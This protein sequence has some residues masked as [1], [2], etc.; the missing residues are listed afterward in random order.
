MHRWI[1][2]MMMALTGALTGQTDTTRR[3]EII[4][5]KPNKIVYEDGESGSAVIRLYN[6]TD[7][8]MQVTLKPTLIW[9]LDQRQELP[10]IDLSV[11]A[12]DNAS[13]E[14]ALPS[15]QRKWGHELRVE[16]L[17]DGKVE[18]VG[19]QFF[20]VN[21]DWM[22]M[23]LLSFPRQKYKDS[24]LFM[25]EEPFTSYTTLQ[26]WFA[27]APGDFAENAPEY[28]E[29]YSGQTGY[30]MKKE[31]LQKT[32]KEF[33]AKGIHCTFYN[34]AFTNGKAG[35][36][37]ARRYPEW[38]C[39]QRDG[40]PMM[41]GSPLALT[42][43]YNDKA[44]GA[45][46]QANMAF[47]DP[48]CI[49]YGARNVL[50]SIEIFGWDGMFWDC[51]G[52]ALFPG[53][54]YDGEPTPHGQEPNAISARNFRMLH[55][56]VR[57][58][59]P[60]FGVWINGSAQFA[61][62]PF[63]SRFGNGGGMETLSEQMSTPQTALL[64]EFRHHANPGG[65]YHNWQYCVDQYTLERDNGTQKYGAPIVAGYT[66]FN[67]WAS[68]SHLAA[69][70][71][72]SQIHPANCHQEGSWPMTQFM[73]RYSAFLWPKDV[74]IIADPAAFLSAKTSRPV[75]WEEFVYRRP[76]PN[77]EDIIVHLLNKPVTEN[78]VEGND[79]NPPPATATVSLSLNG[80]KLREVFA[81]Q[82]RPYTPGTDN[83]KG[84]GLDIGGTPAQMER[85]PDPQNPAATI[86]A[87]KRGSLCRGGPLQVNLPAVA[88]DGKVTVEV[89]A[90]VYHTMLVFRLEN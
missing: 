39:R 67:G 49:E 21:T 7:A 85:V 20:G 37:W 53:Y 35:L 58:K 11:P 46:G 26:H 24:G 77:G 41:S 29:W 47:Y 10:T 89:P 50:E 4:S 13:A 14:F 25:N 69:L 31:E 56:M 59:H 83:P 22:E 82:P 19:R 16:A 15:S 2:I 38:I 84:V 28:D 18:D 55:D 57:E 62:Q 80:R 70:L 30:H 3:V 81:A 40:S 54:T 23:I 5:L 9:E 68:Q 32:I 61:E 42:K 6:A 74:K 44:T 1:L 17:V 52:V 34:N 73:T 71:L 12:G 86:W 27:W 75:W 76:T 72:A 66:T 63:W 88:Q 45:M 87:H 64:I 79:E 33:Q 36:E 90:F 78:V 43:P 48:A 65:R 60:S 51:G 8:V